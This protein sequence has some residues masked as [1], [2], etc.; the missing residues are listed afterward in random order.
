M[1]TIANYPLL[2]QTRI[3]VAALL[4][5]AGGLVSL[6]LSLN[7]SVETNPQSVDEIHASFSIIWGAAFLLLALF[8][9]WRISIQRPDHMT[10]RLFFTRVV[11]INLICSALILSPIAISSRVLQA[12]ASVTFDKDSLLRSSSAVLQVLVVCQKSFIDPGIS[13]QGTLVEMLKPHWINHCPLVAPS[14]NMEGFIRTTLSENLQN[15]PLGSHDLYELTWSLSNTARA[16]TSSLCQRMITSEALPQA[17]EAA[18]SLSD[19]ATRQIGGDYIQLTTFLTLLISSIVL[20]LSGRLAP[21]MGLAGAGLG[22]FIL[23]LALGYFR[24][25]YFDVTLIWMLLAVGLI[26]FFIAVLLAVLSARRQFLRSIGSFA[27]FFIILQAP[28]LP[29]ILFLGWARGEPDDICVI[30]H[31]HSLLFGA[32]GVPLLG[33]MVAWVTLTCALFLPSLHFERMRPS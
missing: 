17:L 5:F 23:T 7:T 9:G 8:I 30:S 18:A 10:G 19:V 25:L 12:R 24:H 1:R 26:A 6:I 20:S 11:L 32:V 14:D 27:G 22:I 16:D 21:R 4:G 13:I 29:V 31:D 28:A 2:W 15:L 3:H 33:C